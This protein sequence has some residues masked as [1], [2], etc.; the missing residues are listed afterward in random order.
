MNKVYKSIILILFCTLFT[1]IAQIFYKLGADRLVFTPM[2]IITN[3][4]IGIGLGLY[5]I[6]AA[7]L[8]KALKGAD[9]SILYPIIST[10]YIWVT[11]LSVWIFKETINVYKI[12]GIAIII[13]GIIAMGFGSKDNPEPELE[14]IVT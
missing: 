2:G 11:I 13:G 8:I 14:V 9:L 12:V 6:G 4:H 1:S 3:Y 7:I 10:S 5:A